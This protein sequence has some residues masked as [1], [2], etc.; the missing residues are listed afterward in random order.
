MSIDT[1]YDPFLVGF[2]RHKL[3]KKKGKK[4]KFKHVLRDQFMPLPMLLHKRKKERK[5][6]KR[7]AQQ[8]KPIRIYRP[9]G[10]Q[11]GIKTIKKPQNMIPRKHVKHSSI[12]LPNPNSKAKKKEISENTLWSTQNIAIMVGAGLTI[13]LL[14]VVITRIIIKK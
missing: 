3:S 1:E 6:A 10:V 11:S 12:A 7:Q 8:K 4:R 13:S 2:I 9:K 14:S 5:R